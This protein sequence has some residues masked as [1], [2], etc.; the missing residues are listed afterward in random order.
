MNESSYTVK[1]YLALPKR[2][3]VYKEDYKISGIESFLGPFRVIDDV[4]PNSKAPILKGVL[5]DEENPEGGITFTMG[6][7]N[8]I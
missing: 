5:T 3:D 6:V 7:V 4:R 1:E 8:I 2:D